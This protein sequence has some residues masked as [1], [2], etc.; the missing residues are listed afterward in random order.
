MSLY[1]GGPIFGRRFA[2]KIWGACFREGLFGG[3]GGLIIGIF[4]Y[5]G[6]NGSRQNWE[7]KQQALEYQSSVYNFVRLYVTISS[8]KESRIQLPGNIP[9][10][11]QYSFWWRSSNL[12]ATCSSFLSFVWY[13]IYTGHFTN[14]A[15]MG[16]IPPSREHSLSLLEASS[17]Y[18]SIFFSWN[19]SWMCST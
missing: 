16:D 14:R 17:R 12:K 11:T 5:F 3:G 4:Q 15:C 7:P 9:L 6:K 10:L 19:F 8:C 13:L 18:L 1:S 2:S